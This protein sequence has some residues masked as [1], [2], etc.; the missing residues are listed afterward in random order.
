MI[1]E[2]IGALNDLEKTIGHLKA[3]LVFQM[4]F[5]LSKATKV[6]S[7][8]ITTKAEDAKDV[9]NYASTS[10]AQAMLDLKKVRLQIMCRQSDAN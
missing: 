1:G 4:E 2:T 5:D 6:E 7:W 8:E 3:E 10:L 9:A